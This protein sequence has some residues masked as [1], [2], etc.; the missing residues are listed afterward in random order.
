MKEYCD[1][2]GDYLIVEGAVYVEGDTV[3][4]D[5]DHDDFPEAEIH[6][7]EAE[8]KRLKKALQ[9]ILDELEAPGRLSFIDKMVR[10]ALGKPP[11]RRR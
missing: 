7:L 11:R 1:W 5:C 4:S 2:C 6:R 8:N 9:E 3:C 10:E